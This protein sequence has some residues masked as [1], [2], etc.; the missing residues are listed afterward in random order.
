MAIVPSIRGA[1]LV[2]HILDLGINISAPPDGP[3]P[4]A[5]KYEFP[6]LRG[7]VFVGRLAYRYVSLVNSARIYMN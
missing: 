1:D 7:Q 4:K 3:K 5:Y 2:T 6:I